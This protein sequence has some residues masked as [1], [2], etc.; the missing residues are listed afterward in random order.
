M[1]FIVTTPVN[2]QYDAMWEIQW[3]VKECTIKKT[4][5]RGLLLMEADNTAAQKIKEYDTTA[6][7]RVIP[8]DA[9][10][11]ADL[12]T[13]TKT[14]ISIAEKKLTTEES[15][16][17]RCK[18][19]EFPVP[20]MDI[21]AKIG[22]EIVEKFKNPVNLK[23]PDKVILIEII[24]KKAGIAILKESEIIKKEVLEL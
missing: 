16:A 17:V 1:Y 11:V 3:A 21:E 13:I 12:S 6:V 19:R 4:L 5:Y 10:V 8:L 18:R 14:V 22:A 15:F 24:H 20:S 9:F 7:H 2:R 23:T